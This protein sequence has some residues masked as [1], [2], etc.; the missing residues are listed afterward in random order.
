[1]RTAVPATSR[2]PVCLMTPCSALP[3]AASEPPA[4]PCTSTRKGVSSK[5]TCRHAFEDHGPVYAGPRP[6][7]RFTRVL[8]VVAPESQRPR[9]DRFGPG[10][11][12][13]H[14][15][16]GEP[17]PI[18]QRDGPAASRSNLE[19]EPE[20]SYRLRKS[21][22]FDGKRVADRVIDGAK[23]EQ[24]GALLRTSARYCGPPDHLYRNPGRSRRRAC[25][26]PVPLSRCQGRVPPVACP[27]P[28]P[29]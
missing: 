3:S 14:V 27:C 5:S 17:C 22:R 13:L 10:S 15:I 1:M 4:S 29:P 19:L 25:R 6:R 8:K 9:C 23:V 20:R 26:C 7:H 16:E 12:V 2:A 11:G 21:T 24:F 28:P 18:K